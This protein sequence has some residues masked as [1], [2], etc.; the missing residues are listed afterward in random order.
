MT[1]QKVLQWLVWVQIAAAI[2]VPVLPVPAQTCPNGTLL[3]KED[4]GGNSVDDPHI[5]TTPITAMDKAYKQNTSGKYPSISSGRYLVTKKGYANGDTTSSNPYSQWYIQDDHTYPN[6]YTRGYFLQVDGKDG[7]HTFYSTELTGLCADAQLYFSAYVANVFTYYQQSQ[8]TLIGRHTVEPNLLFVI[9]DAETGQEFMR[10]TTGPIAPDATLP[11]LGDWRKSST[12]HQVGVSLRIPTGVNAVKL[13][14]SNSAEGGIGNDFALDDIEVRLCLPPV[15]VAAADTICSGGTTTFEGTFTNNGTFTEP[16]AYRWLY[17]ATG[18]LTSQD[19]WATIGSNSNKLT[20]E[21]TTR[22]NE[23]YYRLAVASQDGLD[24]INCRAMSDPIHLS[25]REIRSEITDTICAGESYRFNARTLTATGTYID[26]L[27]TLFGCDSIITL[28]LHVRDEIRTPLYKKLCYGDSLLFGGKYRTQSGTYID[29]L[30]AISGCDSIVTLNLQIRSEIR[31]ILYQELCHGDSMLFAGHFRTQSGTYNDTLTTL[32]GCDS[33]VTLNL[34]IKPEIRTTLDQM[35]CYG[36][37]MLFGG[38]Y[39]TQ[40]GTYIDTLTAISGCDSIVTLNLHIKPEIKFTLEQMLCY[41]DSM[42]FGGK[43]RTQSG[44]YIDTLTT[45]FGCDSIV[46]LNLHIKPE[47][48]TTLDQILCYGD[49]MLFGGKYRTQSGIYIDTLTA[50]S[51]CDSIVTLKLHVSDEIRTPLYKKLCYGDSLLFGGKYRTQSGTY[52]DTLTAISGCDSIV[53]LNLQIR[54]EIRSILYQELCHGDS[55]LFAGH[56]RTQSSTY[57]DTL[58]AASGCDSIVVLRLNI[59]PEIRST[60]RRRICEDESYFFHHQQLNKSGLY[61]DTLTAVSGCDSIV[62]LELTVRHCEQVTAG[63]DTAYLSV[64]DSIVAIGLSDNDAWTCAEPTFTLITQPTIAGATATIYA[65]SLIYR[66][67]TRSHS[68]RDSLQYSINCGEFADT[69]IIYLSITQSASIDIELVPN[70][71]VCL[72]NYAIFSGTFKN[73]GTLTPPLVCQWQ[74][75]ADDGVTWAPINK[76]RYFAGSTLSEIYQIN[77]AEHYLFRLLVTEQGNES[78]EH[79]YVVSNLLPIDILS[80]TETLTLSGCGRV[81]YDGKTYT[82]DTTFLETGTTTSTCG[83]RLVSIQVFDAPESE[84]TILF[85]DTITYNGQ[86][87]YTDTTIVERFASPTNDAT[88]C[89]STATTHLIM[90]CTAGGT[91]IEDLIV[92]KYDWI[93]LCNNRKAYTLVPNYTQMRYQWYRNGERIE[94]ATDDYYT[95]S[96][97]LD[98]CYMLRLMMIDENTAHIFVSETKCVN[99]HTISIIPNPVAAGQSA[100]IEYYFSESDKQGLYVDIYDN[101]GLLY[102]HIEPTTY[103]IV[104]P[105]NLA[106]G[107]YNIKV[108]TGLGQIFNVKLIVN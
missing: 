31:S 21:N 53:N 10:S 97:M 37:S 42:L 47:I 99:A 103:P 26:T 56:F 87:F 34:H 1:R 90:N 89:D 68:G 76:W 77:D 29:T 105:S 8:R 19:D 91:Y 63:N 38:K 27:T 35:L 64:C 92:N 6:D 79:C 41:G 12:W 40:S 96:R 43:Y 51:G 69:A 13:T 58:T 78:L 39:R 94:G 80:D 17:S 70:A 98:G 67:A 86:L 28:K 5:S 65:D 54:S 15:S 85:C 108:V 9:S 52:I 61:A 72:Y 60:I 36:D 59:R 50:A 82:A 24:R 4:F 25:V 2:L 7:A 3:F 83:N 46:T 102:Y 32:F 49:S 81:E 62:T 14:I 101:V 100:V 106:V 23:G 74:T 16:L 57:N 30:T 107:I 66:N 71:P 73:N 44:T 22:S 75:S 33:I 88:P 20:L 48:R 45:L 55:L 18:N 93:M 104:L 11:E 84:Q 95:E